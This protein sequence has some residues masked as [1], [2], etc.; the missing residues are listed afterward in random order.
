MRRNRIIPV[1]FTEVE[2]RII[3]NL[4]KQMGISKSEVIRR[5]IWTVRV[6]FSPHLPLKKALMKTRGTSLVDALRP[7]PELWDLIL[8]EIAKEKTSEI[9]KKS[10]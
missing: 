6:L 4:A 1:R 3:S 7:I 2:Y 10:Q 9:R 5:L 8:T